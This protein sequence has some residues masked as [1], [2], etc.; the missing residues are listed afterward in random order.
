MTPDEF[1]GEYGKYAIRGTRFTNVFPSVTLAQAILESGWGKSDLTTQANNFFGIKATDDWSG[2]KVLMTTQEYENNQYITIQD[3]FRKYTNPKKSFEDHIQFLKDNSRYKDNGVFS[4]KTPE[5]QATALQK[6]G[7]ATSPV[8]ADKLISIIS[9]YDLK[10]LDNRQKYIWA[11]I[12]GGSLMTI[13]V[14]YI[15]LNA[16][17]KLPKKL[18]IKKLQIKH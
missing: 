9:D 1:I 6:A 10:K 11:W 13:A 17:K 5:E 12:I 4:A 7:Y 2:E 15:T 16:F 14:G 3:W 8:Y 18:E